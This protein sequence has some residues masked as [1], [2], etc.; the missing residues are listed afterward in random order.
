MFPICWS[1]SPEGLVQADCVPFKCVFFLLPTLGLS[2]QRRGVL[3]QVGLVCLQRSDALS[4][5]MSVVPLRC[6]PRLC[7]FPCCARLWPA[8]GGAGAFTRLRLGSMVRRQQLGQISL[9]PNWG[10]A[11]TPHK[12]N[13]G[14]S[15]L[16]LCPSGSP[17]CQGG[18]SPLHR[19][20][21]LGSPV[22]GSIHSLL[23][24]RVCPY[25][26]PFLLSPLPGAQV[27]I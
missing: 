10:Q 22:C 14:F 26:L 15:S 27:P 19:T 16:S 24:M 13:L 4:V 5:Q 23:S 25:Y 7:L 20:P 2:P 3:K 21:G 9:C 8:V 6:S 1:R 18:L 12:W 17:G 11:S